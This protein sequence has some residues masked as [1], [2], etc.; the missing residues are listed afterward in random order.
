M[1]DPLEEFRLRIKCD[2]ITPSHRCY[3]PP[4]WPPPGDWPV[5]EDRDGKTVSCWKDSIWDLSPFAG[6][7]FQLNFGDGP[8]NSR[9]VPLDPAN[10]E[11]L[12]RVVGWHM[13]GPRA[14]RSVE[15]L[16]DVFTYLR[17]IFVLCSHNR[18]LVSELMRFPKV[19]KQVP[20]RIA[21]SRYDMA[22]ASLHRLWD[23]RDK[24]GFVLVDPGGIK[25][26]VAARPDHV[27]V[28]TAYIPPRI[29]TY[30]MQ[31]LRECLDDFLSH[32]Q[33]VED[34]FN[35]C[36]D[37]YSNN[38]GSLEAA[39]TKRIGSR[40]TPFGKTWKCATTIA[41]REIR[42]CGTFRATAERFGID[43]LLDRWVV[44]PD[45]EMDVS[46]LS[47]YLT[48]VQY[49]GLAYI[50]NFTLQRIKEASS[51]RADCLLWEE[52]P[53]LGRVPIIVGETT[54]TDP[55][56]DAWWPTSPSVKVPVSAM[57][58]IARLRMRCAAE[59]PKIGVAK[60][61]QDNPYLLSRS[62]EPWSG[63]QAVPYTTRPL[64]KAYSLLIA[65]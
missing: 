29:W 57:S 32:R 16:G 17:S 34:C 44:I 64:P 46:K 21:P 2:W 20:A 7:P 4:S 19:L 43:G 10:A 54:K 40:Y 35:F 13:F 56:S 15:S 6:F 9:S 36:L 14:V 58:C 37:V 65:D 11:L 25:Q 22:I 52:D 53:K 30:Q 3:R 26:L 49:A 33:K 18:I 23:V 47:A 5:I 24:I 41:G 59:N 38:A 55:D 61:D 60:V 45:Q 48:L 51:L 31:R 63:T 50:A 62:D 28:Q 12:R 8:D 39:V 27:K 42:V 1:T